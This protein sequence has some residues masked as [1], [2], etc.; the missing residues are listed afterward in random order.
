M[1][2]TQ[3]Q[4]LG[5]EDPLKKGMPP[6]QYSCLKNSMDRRAW[7]AS[8]HGV[9]KSWTRLTLSLFSDPIGWLMIAVDVVLPP[10]KRK[11]ERKLWG[12]H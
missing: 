1:Q 8:V 2:E 6:T 10:L 11:K 9:T 4:S 3:V 5:W 7:W 12:Q